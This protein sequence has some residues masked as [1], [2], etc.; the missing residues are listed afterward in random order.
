MSYPTAAAD[1]RARRAWETLG[2]IAA[3]VLL[4]AVVLGLVLARIVRRPL[5]SLT[6]AAAAV[7]AGD[8]SARAEVTGP[9]ETRAVA[10]AFN[11]MAARLDELLRAQQSFAADAAHELRSPLQALRLRLEN[12]DDEVGP[13]GHRDLE[14]AHAEALRLSRLV[15]G[16]LELARAEDAAQPD[17]AVELAPAVARRIGRWRELAAEAGIRLDVSVPGDLRVLAASDRVEQVVENLIANAVAASPSGGVIAVT[18]VRA[19]AQVELRVSDEGRGLSDEEK[20]RAFDR[21]W[22]G[23]ETGDG[24]GLGLAIVRRLVERDGGSVE[25]RDAPG[26]GL[27]AVVH[28]PA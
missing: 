14:A 12:L 5:E 20:A 22:R 3:V 13:G 28:L 17:A 4:I 15:T 6:A 9:P 8:L 11:L 1:A 18:A 2:A 7:G 27:E 16:L 23:R 24:S 25:L 26:G 19:G 21:F 10:S